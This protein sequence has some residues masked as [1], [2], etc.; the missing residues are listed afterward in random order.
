MVRAALLASHHPKSVW[1]DALRH[2]FFAYNSFLCN[3]L[4]GFKTPVQSLGAN[5]AGNSSVV[6]TTSSIS[7][8][9]NLTHSPTAGQRKKCQND[10]QDM[11]NADSVMKSICNKIQSESYSLV[12]YDQD[13]S[14]RFRPGHATFTGSSVNFISFPCLSFTSSTSIT[15]I[16]TRHSTPD[17]LIHL[18]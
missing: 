13:P 16:A 3:T 5:P 15:P 6:G 10:K 12:G 4:L 2:S 11:V 17:A 14:S 9:T 7:P 18:S 8:C 1:T